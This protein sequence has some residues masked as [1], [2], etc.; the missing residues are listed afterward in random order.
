MYILSVFNRFGSIIL[1]Q[2]NLAR[3]FTIFT[4]DAMK[5]RVV[6]SDWTEMASDLVRRLVASFRKEQLR[7]QGEKSDY[8][9]RQHVSYW[10]SN[11][12]VS[13]AIYFV[14]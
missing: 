6:W 5:T 13:K 11:Y 2:F 7:L 12:Q 1:Y 4:E 3:S 14:S 10:K 8:P 9:G